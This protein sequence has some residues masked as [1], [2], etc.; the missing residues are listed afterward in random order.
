M[1]GD[2]M[3]RL[4]ASSYLTLAA[5]LFLISMGA[6]EKSAPK[7]REEPETPASRTTDQFKSA[8]RHFKHLKEVGFSIPNPRDEPGVDKFEEGG[9]WLR[10]STAAVQASERI[11]RE[12]REKGF[13]HILEISRNLPD[14]LT[15]DFHVDGTVSIESIRK[16]LGKENRLHT[17]ASLPNQKNKQLLNPTDNNGADRWH[18]YDDWIEFGTQDEKVMVI[19]LIVKKYR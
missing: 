2:L 11:K 16:E 3:H 7:K 14:V 8:L 15:L 19:R 17:S 9:R 18:E 4:N 13:D 12:I 6:C 10:Q 1:V 5:G